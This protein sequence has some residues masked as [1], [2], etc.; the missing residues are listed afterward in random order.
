MSGI[1]LFGWHTLNGRL[2][3]TVLTYLYLRFSNGCLHDF[4][5]EFYAQEHYILGVALSFI[6]NWDISP[7]SVFLFVQVASAN[8]KILELF[9]LTSCRD[10]WTSDD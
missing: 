7:M 8:D 3:T 10:L 9:V 5:F 2:L 6:L 4:G 1:S